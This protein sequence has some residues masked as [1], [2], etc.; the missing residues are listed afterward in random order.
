MEETIPTV[1]AALEGWYTFEWNPTS[2]ESDLPGMKTFLKV[3]K[4]YRGWEPEDIVAAYIKCWIQTAI[5]V[6]GIRLGLEKAGFENL[7]GQAVRDGLA[8][9][10]DFDAGGLMPPMSMD[11]THPY[12]T[13]SIRLFEVREGRLW[14]TTEKRYKYYGIAEEWFK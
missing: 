2:V 11:D 7:T 3:V 10:K 4:E 5:M 8:R 9:I 14:P 13:R 1:G 6:E 12:W